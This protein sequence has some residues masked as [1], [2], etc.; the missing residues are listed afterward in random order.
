MNKSYQE[1]FQ[2][3]TGGFTPYPWQAHVACA[4][5]PEVL[6]VPTGLGKTEGTVLAWAYRRLCMESTTE[7]RHLVYCLPMRVLVQQT[8]DRLRA[9]FQCLREQNGIDVGVH[10]LMGG[11]VDEAWVRDPEKLWVLIGTQD[12]LLS[13][14]L[15]RGYG[16]NRFEWPMHF[17]LLN[18]DCRWI[19]D[20]VQLMGP[21]LW[22]TAQ[23]DWMRQKRFAPLF[24]CPTTWM[25][26]TLGLEFLA[27]TDR[28]RDG[29]DNVEA[30][31]MKWDIPRDASDALRKRMQD[32]CDAK[33]PIEVVDPPKGTKAAPWPTWLVDRITKEHLPGTLSLIICN[34]VSKAREVF[35]ALPRDLPKILLTSRF[36]AQDRRGNEARLVEFEACRKAASSSA[37]PDD[38][39]L[40][41]VSTQ[42]VEAGMD[43]SA[44]RLW[45]EIAPWPSVVQ[46]LGRLNRG[47]LDQQAA[48]I[49]WSNEK[50]IKQKDARIGPYLAEEIAISRDLIEAL[51]RESAQKSAREALMALASKLKTKLEKALAPKPAPLPR[52]I[53]VH[54][55]FSIERDLFGGFTD[56]SAFVRDT[57]PDADV[58]VFWRAWPG[59]SAPRE[60]ELAG[61]DFD[62]PEA[63]AVPCGSLQRFLKEGRARIWMWNDED[64][65]WVS[66]SPGDMRADIMRY[67]LTKGHGERPKRAA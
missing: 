29:L 21:G 16:M 11:N 45:S 49:F 58:A 23:L 10:V 65:R 1:F 62:P 44:H 6:S 32:L 38:P 48:A 67:L 12:M 54:G 36:R 14:A 5:L 43:I 18:N 33:R 17:G 31:V 22:T 55:L 42:V 50:P 59:K 56:I 2:Q 4:G 35:E 39:G 9:C 13:R 28:K 26:A 51:V 64:G 27:T 52:A 15:N 63:V 3:A 19:V 24:P 30:Y 61:P 34:T 25:S 40:I 47:G 53:D 41:C 46:R 60:D 8:N 20:E 66:M 7:P 37:I 57:D